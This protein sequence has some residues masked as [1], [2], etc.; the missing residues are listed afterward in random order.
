MTFSNYIQV[1]VGVCSSEECSS[2]V[3]KGI[4]N[5]GTIKNERVESTGFVSKN[6]RTKTHI[7]NVLIRDLFTRLVKKTVAAQQCK[8]SWDCCVM[9]EG[10]G[11]SVEVVDKAV[12]SWAFATPFSST[13]N[14]FCYFARV[15]LGTVLRSHPRSRHQLHFQKNVSV[16]HMYCINSGVGALHRL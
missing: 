9:A 6:S 10:E 13:T 8:V 14:P 4:G 12:E 2:R 1:C 7:W 3:H 11:L 16:Y 5:C 15:F